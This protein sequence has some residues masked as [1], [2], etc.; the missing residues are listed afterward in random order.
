[1]ATIVTLTLNPTISS[2]PPQ[3]PAIP[4]NAISA[5]GAG[6][7]FVSGMVCAFAAGASIEEAIRHGLAAATATILSPGTDLCQKA[8]VDRLL[9]QIPTSTPAIP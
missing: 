5:V 8:D 7:S 1:M 3:R 6:D 2:T 9:A 4:V